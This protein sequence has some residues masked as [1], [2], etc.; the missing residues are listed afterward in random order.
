MEF[1]RALEQN[2]DAKEFFQKLAPTYRK[3]FNGWIS[4]AK[5][6][7]TKEKRIKESI[8]L[9]STGQKLGLK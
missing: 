4:I 9:L 5:R 3:E 6:P 8:K 2:T 7:E 1:K